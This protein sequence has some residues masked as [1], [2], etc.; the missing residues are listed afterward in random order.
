M[1][2]LNLNMQIFHHICGSCIYGA[3]NVPHILLYFSIF[4]AKFLVVIIPLHIIYLSL[5]KCRANSYFN[6]IPVVFNM[7]ISIIF[8]IFLSYLI[9]HLFYEPR[10]FLLEPNIALLSHRNS[11]SFPSDHAIF[12]SIYVYFLIKYNSQI[13]YVKII[14]PLAII[15]MILTCWARV[16]TAIH[17]PI[18]IIGGILVGIISSFFVDKLYKIRTK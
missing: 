8:A 9:A 5:R 11:A 13:N 14:L 12:F 1:G 6:V 16:F 15:F 3:D 18:D 10:P 7:V 17:Y 4:C 2:L